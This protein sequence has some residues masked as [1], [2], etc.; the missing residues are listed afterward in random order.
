MSFTQYD[1]KPFIYEAL[2]DLNFTEPSPIQ[3]SVI[4]KIQAG[5]D[6]IA[7]SQTGSGK[8]HAFLLPLLN[9]ITPEHHTQLV[10]T[11]PSRELAEQLYQAAR[12][13]ISFS[14][15]E[16]HIERA[17]GG[18]DTQ[19]Q[20]SRLESNMPQ[21][22]VGTPGRLL[23]L[24]DNNKI[25]VHQVRDFVVDEADMTLDLGFL[26]VV[27]QIAGRMPKNLKMYVFSATLPPKLKPFLMK[28]MSN[29]DWS[30]IEAK[31]KISDTIENLLVPVKGRDR[32]ALLF[33][34]LTIGQ[35]YLALIFANTKETVE[36]IY[37]YLKS[38][39]LN[40]GHIHGDLPARERRRVMKQVQNLDFQYVVATDLAAR[41]IDIDGVSHVINY[42][43]PNELEFFIHR[44]GRTGRQGKPG[45]AITFYIPEE[46]KDIEWLEN[47]GIKF[48][49]KDIKN[50]QMIDGKDHDARSAR[51][52]A[53]EVD[54]AVAGMIE[55]TKRSKVKPGYKKKLSRQIAKHNKDTRMKDQRIKRR[56]QRKR[57]KE[58]N[59]VDY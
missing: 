46:L 50:H 53:P 42:E 34:T 7:Q 13:I 2:A 3:A 23:D 54:N 16:I 49:F 14:P 26:N 51:Q 58:E 6:V 59:K 55:R 17:F 10:I 21:I 15:D 22:V 1:F 45:T 25:S 9:K 5:R 32:K 8:S 44:V 20:A 39:G 27:D 48:E 18:T 35:P 43:V 33:D 11:A 31:N 41:G 57:N 29:P 40:V 30:T 47:K 12:Q 52:R 56:D 37:K 28:Y 19:K 4:P 36:E 24:V 38:Q